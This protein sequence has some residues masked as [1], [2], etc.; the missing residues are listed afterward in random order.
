MINYYKKDN[1]YFLF[2]NQILFLIYKKTIMIIYL[3]L[4][5]N[6]EISCICYGFGKK[7]GLLVP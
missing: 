2:N 7:I 4:L 3:K 6:I 5:R 1:I